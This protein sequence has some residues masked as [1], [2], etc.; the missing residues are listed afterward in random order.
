MNQKILLLATLL[1]VALLGTPAGPLGAFLLLWLLPIFSWRLWLPGRDLTV[2]GLVILFNM[3]LTLLL[4]LWPGGLGRPALL[5]MALL[6][7]W[8]P[9]LWQRFAKKDGQKAEQPMPKLTWPIALVLLL[10]V[11]LRLG[12]MGY[13]EFQGDE[14]LIMSRAAASLMGDEQ[15][16]FLHQKGPAEIL[17][18]MAMWGLSG[19]INEFWSRL[20]FTWASCLAV[21]AVMSLTGRWF[22]RPAGILAGLLLAL[23]GFAIAFGRIVQYQSLVMLWGALA[24]LQADHYRQAGRRS[25]LIL[26][27]LFAA[28]GLL[29]HYDTVLVL[30]AVAWLVWRR[31]QWADWLPAG[32]V[33]LFVLAIFY[34]P[35]SLSPSFAATSRYLLDDRV[36]GGWLK[37]SFPAGWHT[38]TF[39]NSSWFVVGLAVLALAGVWSLW[40]QRAHF[41]LL[42]AVAVPLF[43][44]TFLVADPRTHVYTIFPAL[45]IL[46]AAGATY[47]RLHWSWLAIFALVSG[48]Y[49]FLIFVDTNPER[50]RTWAENRPAFYPTTWS[51]L[52]TYGLFGFPYQAGW[53]VVADLLPAL[54]Y[55]SNEEGEI[56][57]W[58][59]AQAPRTYCPDFETF[60]VAEN[61]Q[62]S[63]PFDPAGLQSLFLRYQITVNGRPKLAIYSRSPGREPEVIEAAGSGRWLTPAQM[64][65]L[66]PEPQYP[67]AAELGP[68][69]VR[70]LGYDVD[71][72]RDQQLLVTLYWQSLAPFEQNYQVYVHLADT[73]LRAQHDGAPACAIYPTTRWEPGQI[74]RDPHLLDLPADLP[75]GTYQLTAGMYEL[76][77]LQPLPAGAIPLQPITIAP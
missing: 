41:A 39:Y 32:T 66:R 11:A 17:L 76:L 70:L 59:M 45:T 63:L 16:L 40:R 3:L 36:G 30:P 33:G 44:Y 68:N 6:T 24:L 67:L 72:G 64:A 15:E 47:F 52:P 8:L 71:T 34:L 56:T 75:A 48:L 31:G 28:G 37:W 21:I 49:V 9:Q 27:T 53:R 57:N 14:G 43:F 38:A 4:A 2:A 55:A 54:P 46:A 35:F 26:T 73:I 1:S 13:K 20:P 10:A 12:N 23:N 22:G 69:Q 58:Y 65:P 62:D 60:I 18:P 77:T 19:R 51:E 29:A 50:Q 5:L 74:I 61:V 42:L 25:D 7:L